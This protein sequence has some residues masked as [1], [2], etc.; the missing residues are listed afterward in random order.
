MKDIGKYGLAVVVAVLIIIFGM[1]NHV[2][3]SPSNLINVFDQIAIIGI[4]ALGMT[5][6]ILIGGIDLSVGSIVAF[7]GIVLA[8]C[9]VEGSSLP[10]SIFLCLLT[11]I[12]LGLVNGFFI[13]YGKVPAF[14]ATLGLMSTA[15]G[16]ALYLTDGRS[17]SG[18]PEGLSYFV[19]TPILG[20]S[21]PTIILVFLSIAFWLF[22]KFTYWGKYIYAIGG[23]EKAAWLS[24]IKIKRY[25]LFVYA[26]S[27]FASAVSCIMLVGKL[28][29]AQPQAGNMYEL[30][31][32]AAVVIGG[33]SLSGGKGEIWKT[34]LG[35]LILGILQNGFSILNI[36]SYYQQILIGLIIIF[37]VIIDSKSLK[38]NNYEK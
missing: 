6:V 23:N 13:A 34:F 36:P 24:G 11:G 18:L 5:I 8:K 25:K 31:A 17:V 7:A 26:I 30:N 32:I 15:R 1:L 35:V 28:N 21:A 37:A 38:K 14:I 19:T 9:L 12:G 29:S 4:I 33:A 22:L 3:I 16:A 27:G 20:F 2:F 10:L